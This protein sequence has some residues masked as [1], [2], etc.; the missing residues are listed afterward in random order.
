MGLKTKKPARGGLAGRYGRMA[1]SS[2]GLLRRKRKN[3]PRLLWAG[4]KIW[5]HLSTKVAACFYA[6]CVSPALLL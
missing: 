5:A 4:Q 3:P 1:A 6:G 2:N